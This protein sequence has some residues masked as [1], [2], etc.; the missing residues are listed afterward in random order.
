M[1]QYETSCR[2]CAAGTMSRTIGA[3]SADTCELCAPG[4]GAKLTL[5][6]PIGVYMD[7]VDVSGW[8]APDGFGALRPAARIDL[9][10]TDALP[11][12]PAFRD[13]APAD[14][15]TAHL[16]ALRARTARN[17]FHGR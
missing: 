9:V 6:D 8:A 14:L 12:A 13:G 2:A 3:T 4:N 11:A 17:F 15:R 16:V 7:E 10:L 1:G 5:S